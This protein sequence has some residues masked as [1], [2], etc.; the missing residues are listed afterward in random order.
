MPRPRTNDPLGVSDNP[1]CVSDPV[2]ELEI[3]SELKNRLAYVG[4][5]YRSCVK[6]IGGPKVY[7]DALRRL[8]KAVAGTNPADAARKRLPPL[9]EM[10]VSEKARSF[11]AERTGDE[12]AVVAGED[13]RRAAQWAAEELKPIA[14]RPHASILRLHVEG[15]MALLQEFAG[16][17]VLAGRYINSD[18]QPHFKPGISQMV[19]IFFQSID[20]AITTEQ[21]VTIVEMA[22]RKYAGKRMAFADFFPLYGARVGEDGSIVAR[23]GWRVEHFQPNIPTYFH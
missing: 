11:A 2:R 21:L 19:P 4:Q 8:R 9:I 5:N 16:K 10:A 7:N 15:L 3:S 18:Y 14:N 22:R 17:P 13:I 20:P 6:F 12:E 1:V 23:T